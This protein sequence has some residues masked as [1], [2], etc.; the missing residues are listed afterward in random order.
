MNE[1]TDNIKSK[2]K[3]LSTE[4]TTGVTVLSQIHLQRCQS[5]PLELFLKGVPWAHF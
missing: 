2:T 1:R 4:E 3:E 5:T